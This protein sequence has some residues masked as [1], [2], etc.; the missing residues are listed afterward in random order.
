MKE[1]YEKPEKLKMNPQKLLEMLEKLETTVEL[2]S[3][4]VRYHGKLCWK[5]HGARLIWIRRR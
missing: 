3:I 2:H 4:S 1:Y 5:E